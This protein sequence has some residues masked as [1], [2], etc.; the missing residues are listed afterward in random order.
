RHEVEAGGGPPLELEQNCLDRLGPHLPAVGH[1]DVAELTLERASAGRLNA[2]DAIVLG[3][4][5]VEPRR[6]AVAH[7]DLVR[8]HVVSLVRAA[9]PVR[10]ELRP[11]VLAFAFEEHIAVGT[12]PFG[13]HVTDRSAHAD[14][15]TSPPEAVRDLEEPRFLDRHGGERDEVAWLIEIDV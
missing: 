13:K 5:Q 12:T 7:I 15:Y 4:E 8:L 2:A 14:E 6:W 10:Q 9:L 3:L 1:D 11:R